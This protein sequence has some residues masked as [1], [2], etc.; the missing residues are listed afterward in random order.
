MDALDI[1]GGRWENPTMSTTTA[2]A[3]KRVV[4][5]TAR[6]GDVFDIQKQTEGCFLLVRLERPEPVIRKSRR[7]CLKAID[8]LPLQPSMS[9]EEL[10]RLTREP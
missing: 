2:D 1:E 5:P 4:V 10:R 9:W 6:P 3:K 8:S 7:E